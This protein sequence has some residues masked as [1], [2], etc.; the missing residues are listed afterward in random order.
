MFQETAPHPKDIDQ[1]NINK[2]I[3]HV[4]IIFVEYSKTGLVNKLYLIQD[5]HKR[6]KYVSMK[7]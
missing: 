2:I 5:Y 4:S 3:E 7:L 1:V 6:G